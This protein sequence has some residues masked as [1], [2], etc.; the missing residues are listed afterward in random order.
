MSM[1]NVFAA[2]DLFPVGTDRQLGEE[3]AML[4][5]EVVADP[6][7]FLL[8]N[9][10]VYIRRVGPATVQT[11]ATVQARTVR[12]QIVS[13]AGALCRDGRRQIVEEATEIVTRICGDAT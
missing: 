8:N 5:A 12:V 6:S 7:P 11:A 1:V 2:A 10:A 4:R 13:Q 3:L 9:T